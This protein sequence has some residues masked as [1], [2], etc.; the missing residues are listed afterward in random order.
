MIVN[1]ASIGRRISLARRRRNLS[2]TELAE[3]AHISTSYVSY[4]ENG[5]RNMSLEIFVELAN[6]LNVSTDELLMDNLPNRIR[7]TSHEMLALLSDCSE[8]EGRVLLSVMRGAKEAMRE[9]VQ[10]KRLE[11]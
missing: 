8:F 10:Q 5:E 4:L 7:T 2:Q 3:M 9:T 1:Y 6:A 11:K